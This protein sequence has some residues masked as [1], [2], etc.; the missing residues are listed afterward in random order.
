[1]EASQWTIKQNK[2]TLELVKREN[3]ELRAALSNLQKEKQ[4][5]RTEKPGLVTVEKLSEDVHELKKRYNDLK[6]LAAQKQSELEA[7][8]DILRE[9]QREGTVTTDADHPTIKSIRVLETKLER[10]TAKCREVEMYQRIYK[11]MKK[12][13]KD[14]RAQFDGQL[15]VAQQSLKAKQTTLS[16]LEV[17]NSE[18]SR[19]RD[20]AKAELQRLEEIIEEERRV[21][22]R[23]LSERRKLVRHAL[24]SLYNCNT[25]A[26]YRQR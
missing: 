10:A 7:K 19:S 15:T 25:L 12:R 24:P 22:E 14:Q 21:R 9:T 23:E 26:R 11:H 6:H 5:S 17:V 1:M 8:Q 3:R 20:A 16:D 2:D 13:L 18:A 4:R